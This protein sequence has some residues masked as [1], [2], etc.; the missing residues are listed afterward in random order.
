MTKRFMALCAAASACL[1][2]AVAP[3]A[4]ASQTAVQDPCGAG[5]SMP[6]GNCGPFT[7]V[8]GENFN[9]DH[10]PLG[11]FS[12]C[13]HNAESAGEVCLGLPSNYRGEFWAYPRG[14]FDTANPKNHSNGNSRTF[15]G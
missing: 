12:D 11:S 8:F 4:Q 7:A 10:I 13:N 2:L 15:G 1:V 9:G 3:R 6:S 5:T 14:W